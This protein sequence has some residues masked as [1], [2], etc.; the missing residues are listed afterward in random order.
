MP[1]PILNIMPYG[2]FTV[3][4]PAVPALYWNVYSQEQRIKAICE[5][6]HKSDSYMDYVAKTLNR[7]AAE[8]NEDLANEL[9]ALHDD[10]ANLK[11]E[12]IIL[13]EELSAGVL[14]WDVQIGAYTSSVQ[15]M[16]DMFNDVTVHAIDIKTL[17][18]IDGF[19]VA[20]LAECGLNTR[21]LAVMS[22]WLIDNTEPL[23]PEFMA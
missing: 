11:D 22:R 3:S 17:N 7:Y 23:Y 1:L 12:L 15:A 19:T 5:R 8:L 16:R 14:T 13:V 9:E 20:D 2:A 21:G 18:A 10:F 4:P 6:I